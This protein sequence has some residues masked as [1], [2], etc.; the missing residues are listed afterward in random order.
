MIPGEYEYQQ[1]LQKSVASCPNLRTVVDGLPNPELSIYPFLETNFLQFSQKSL[2]VA[3]RK[4]ML[5]SALAGLAALHEKNIA[6]NDIKPNNI[7]LDYEKTGDTFSVTKVQISDLEDALILPLGKYLRDGLC[8]NQ[9]W[10]S[11]ESWARRAAQGTPSD[12]FSFGIV[13]IFVMLNN[14]FFRVSDSELAASNSWRYILRRHI[15]FFGEEDGF[16]GLLQW[17][18]EENPFFERLITLAGTFNAA[19]PRKPFATWH[20]VDAGFR[21]LVGK[22]TVLDPAGRIT[23]AQ[24]LEHPWFAESVDE[25]VL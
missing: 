20:F 8:G 13:C 1:D 23:A 19:E 24:A 5:K 3:T 25:G 11:P 22:M 17:I 10:R 6:H 18:G 2:S 21:D 4:G 12:I 15:S 14:M 9:L 16:Q 7:L